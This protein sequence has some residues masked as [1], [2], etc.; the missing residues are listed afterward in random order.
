MTFKPLKIGDT[1]VEFPVVLAALAGY[2]DHPFRLACRRRGA[3]YCATEMM[4][5]K[6]LLIKGKHQRRLLKV[7]EED[8]PLAGQIIGNDPEIMA[9]AA[10]RL[11]ELGF[12][13]V[14]LNFACPVNKAMKRRRGG[15]LMKQPD[16][17]VDIVRAVV[18]ASDRPVSLKLRRSFDEDD[19]NND[20]FWKITEA[21]FDAGVA[22]ITVHGR[23]VERK[24]TGPADW[25]FI[26]SVKLRFHEKTVIGS[27]DIMEPGDALRMLEETKVDGVAVARG[28]LGNPWFFRQVK[29]ISQG[30][31]PYRP[32]VQ[33]Q[34]D[35]LG[36]HFGQ[37]C[38]LYGD[39]R[40]PKIM[41]K[42]GI[43]Y[44]R[45]HP[46]SKPVRIAFTEIKNAGQWQ[47]VLDKFYSN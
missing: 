17:A 26:S 1:Q 47:G 5:D 43:K 44:A 36:W 14:D 10:K 39:R 23:S 30:Q 45:L 9:G 2:S 46:T 13:V 20:A 11:C 33:E 31:T 34:R 21:A 6:L 4:L 15:Y 24:Y 37:A 35:L 25:E 7:I 16:L 8:H 42:F 29:D 32:S 40:G 19:P 18:A 12:D 38:D 27:G 3:Q 22:A 28:A 41:R